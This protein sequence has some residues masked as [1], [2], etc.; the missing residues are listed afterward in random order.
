MKTKT[1][2]GLSIA[3]LCLLCMVLIYQKQE[4]RLSKK[5]LVRCFPTGEMFPLKNSYARIVY[6]SVYQ[7][8]ADFKLTDQNGSAVTSRLL[9]DK[10]YVANFFFTRCGSICPIMTKNISRLQDEFKSETGI[11]FLS[12][13]VDPEHDSVPVMFQYAQKHHI[14]SKKWHLLTGSR[15]E[16]YELSK[17]SYCLGVETDSPDNFQHSEKL[18]LIDNHRIIR[19][20]YD[21][22]SPAEVDKLLQDIKILLLETKREKSSLNN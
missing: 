4:A 19:G 17:S 16:L 5:K 8:I 10:M 9:K 13:T 15:K 6:D 22:T 21:G 11:L 20:Y 7:T 2:T 3:A 14:D 1:F 18:V 12:H